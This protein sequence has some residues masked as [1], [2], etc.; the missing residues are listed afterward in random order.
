[1]IKICEFTHEQLDRVYDE[2]AKKA[3]PFMIPRRSPMTEALIMLKLGF[4]TINRAGLEGKELTALT[5]IQ[6]REPMHALD[7]EKTEVWA[8]VKL[9]LKQPAA[10]TP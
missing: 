8:K 7:D 10:P 1:M 9:R 4:E 5:I 3:Y 6:R 2:T